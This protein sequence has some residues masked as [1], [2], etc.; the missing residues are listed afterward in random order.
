MPVIEMSADD[1]PWAVWTATTG[2][3]A[4]ASSIC[5]TVT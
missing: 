2:A 1:A 4:S 3:I 5:S